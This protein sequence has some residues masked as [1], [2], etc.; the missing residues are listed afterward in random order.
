VHDPIHELH[1]VEIANERCVRHIHDRYSPACRAGDPPQGL[2]REVLVITESHPVISCRG[3][4]DAKISAVFGGPCAREERGPEHAVAE[5][6]H[7][8]HCELRAALHERTHSR[9][10]SFS[11]PLFQQ[12][13]VGAVEGDDDDFS[14]HRLADHD[15]KL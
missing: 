10:R 4:L 9:Q 12:R 3:W 5:R 6:C 11:T 8:A 7:A 1:A 14:L 15:R 2:A 13:G